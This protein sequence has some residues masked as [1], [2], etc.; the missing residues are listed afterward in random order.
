M[1]KR[2][3]VIAGFGA[4]GFTISWLLFLFYSYAHWIEWNPSTTPLLYLCP[5][6]I[7]SLGL[8]RSSL[9]VGLLGWLLI[10]LSNAVLYS[11]VGIAFHAALRF[12]TLWK[13][14]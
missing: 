11:I 8:D 9:L 10:S 7:L 3:R 2:W 1:R 6:S 5:A 14:D 4:A 12:L 13:S